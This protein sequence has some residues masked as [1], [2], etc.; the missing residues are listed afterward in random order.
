MRAHNE[1]WSTIP[2]LIYRMPLV[3]GDAGEVHL[4]VTACGR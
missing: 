2:V 1:R 4:G 3:V